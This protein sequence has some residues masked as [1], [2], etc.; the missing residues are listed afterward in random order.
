MDLMGLKETVKQTVTMDDVC[1]R[2]NIDVPRDRKIHSI[3]K[4]EKT[5]SLHL[6]KADY[7]DYATGQG[8]DV[9]RFVMDHQGWPFARAVKWLARMGDTAQ[10]RTRRDVPVEQEADLTSE[11]NDIRVWATD[12]NPEWHQVTRERWGI[13]MLTV[14]RM[15]S[16]YSGD[17]LL[18]PHIHG[19]KVRGIKRRYLD[20]RRKD[21]VQGSKYTY[22]LYVPI[23]AYHPA[24]EGS[25]VWIVEGES[26]CWA[27]TD[28][29][30]QGPGEVVY[31]LPSGA[32]LWRDEWRNDLEKAKVIN[33]ALDDDDAGREARARIAGS[34]TT[35]RSGV[36]HVW[37]KG[38]RVAEALML[39]G[40]DNAVDRIEAA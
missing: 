17:L 34:I 27:L 39:S 30:P 23:G 19:G 35:V 33:I 38:G 8:G 15:G 10:I 18:T 3:Y 40:L 24:P 20:G 12:P 13:D 32:S 4:P 7:Y 37:F 5:P 9:I 16:L 6:Y 36:F 25:V 2:L 1:E 21:S 14:I 26:D 31:G 28:A 22:G 29:A 11:W